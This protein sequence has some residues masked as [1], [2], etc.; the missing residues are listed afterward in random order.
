MLLHL[1]LFLPFSVQGNFQY[2]KIIKVINPENIITQFIPYNFFG[3][4]TMR[5]LLKFF[6]LKLNNLLEIKTK[7]HNIFKNQ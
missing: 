3:T 4:K 2:K 5:Y 6:K 1:E 7:S